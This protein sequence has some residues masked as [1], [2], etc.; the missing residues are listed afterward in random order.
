MQTQILRPLSERL[1][2]LFKLAC[3]L[4]FI[5]SLSVLDSKPSFAIGFGDSLGISP[6]LDYKTIHS[7]NFRVT[8][9]VELADTAQLVTGH[10]EDAH[11]ILSKKLNWTPAT[12]TN[13]LVIDNTDSANGLASAFHRFGIVLM[14]TPPEPNY[15][16]AYYDDW[17][18]LLVYHEYTHI[19]NLD[20]TSGWPYKV[21]RVLFG[22]SLLPN[23]F[24]PRWMTEGLAVYMETRLTQLG[25]GRSPYF[26]ALL[27]T[28]V[29]EGALGTSR[30]ATLDQIQGTQAKFPGGEVPY[31]Y[32]YQF[33]NQV[34][35]TELKS[36]KTD[37]QVGQYSYRSGKRFPFILNGLSKGASQKTMYEH[38]DDFIAT[39]KERMTAQIEK[40]K[41]QGETSFTPFTQS[42]YY[43]QG[44]AVSPDGKKIAYAQST[45]DERSGLYIADLTPEGFKN[46][47]KVDDKAQGVGISFT[48]DGKKIFYSSLRQHSLYELYSDI[49]VYDIEAGTTCFLTRGL[50]TSDPSLSPDGKWVAFTFT[51][52]EQTVLA[53]AEVDY[54]NRKLGE[55]KRLYVSAKYGK[56][57]T[58]KFSPSGASIVFGVHT[59]GKTSSEIMTISVSN[60]EN[61][62]TAEVLVDNGAMN[63]Y[64]VFHLDG[65]VY[66]TSDL[67][68]VDN[69]YR[70]ANTPGTI[71]TKIQSMVTN[72]ISAAWLPGF[73]PAGSI[74]PDRPALLASVMTLDGW[75]IGVLNA[76]DEGY[77][78]SSLK[79]SPPNAPPLET[80]EPGVMSEA[81]SGK[82]Y[83]VED[84][85]I[86]PSIL[87]RQWSPYLYIG[88]DSTTAGGAILG[89][90]AL[91]RHRY[92][93]AGAYDSYIQR[94]DWIAA[95]S[96]R[97]FGPTLTA[98]ALQSWALNYRETL[99]K[100]NFDYGAD[101]SYPF[102]ST[103][104][105]FVPSLEYRVEQDHITT[106]PLTTLVESTFLDRMTTARLRFSNT[107][108][109]RLA[110][111]GEGGRY[112]ELAGRYYNSNFRDGEVIKG[113]YQHSEYIHLR[114]LGLTHWVLTPSLKSSIASKKRARY[115]DPG[116][117]NLEGKSSSLIGSIRPDGLSELRV[118]GYPGML[119]ETR[120]ASILAADLTF[121]ISDIFRGIGTLP[122][123]FQ[124][125]YGF[126]FAETTLFHDDH[127]GSDS[128]PSAGGGLRLNTETLVVIP[129]AVSVEYHKGFRTY[130]GGKSEIFLKLDLNGIDF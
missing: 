102:R 55:L 90:D 37:N 35:Q 57:S 71:G 79:V 36:S 67:T 88:T 93:L 69:I 95:Y 89:Y 50:R 78:S 16:T 45:L 63:R 21:L 77:S 104:S 11:K 31:F 121:P 52:R 115:G 68:G 6:H 122:L 125:V 47:V 99:L 128:L 103:Y 92:V 48:P 75:E 130:L 126:G 4:L 91:D 62:G 84:Y 83:P 81:S 10:L 25:R 80:L 24:W 120:A 3:L 74:Y 26:E 65:S 17:L 96:N 72:V 58:P 64:P 9:P 106:Y 42:K 105:V 107:K 129:L 116:N 14:V 70:V 54:E 94:A 108:S 112:V 29:N 34:A 40:I 13:V 32:G 27:R 66:F 15:S 12:K 113:L 38:W 60:K 85:S 97:S 123:F 98:S 28:A 19:L 76:K 100:T 119:F 111:T 87:P 43:A 33:F 53:I 7:D 101:I 127:P 56:V 110:V 61:L 51:E 82:Q 59:N 23:N 39:T 118:R 114:P 2:R 117:V 22:D 30:A 109:S 46:A 5:A 49:K 44:F 20:T 41:S 73:A 8:Y 1:K 18:K 86:F 124:Q